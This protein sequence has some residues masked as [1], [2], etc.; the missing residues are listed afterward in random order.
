MPP[1]AHA[2]VTWDPELAELRRRSGLAQRMGGE[3]KVERHHAQSKLTV[4]E[5]MAHDL[6]LSIARLVDGSGGGG[7]VTTLETMRASFVPFNPAWEWV[8]ANLSTVPVVSLCLG[9]VAG[10]GAARVVTSRY[11]VM[12]QGTSQLFVAG[13]PVVK[14]LGE[15]VDKE[16]L[17]GSHS[18]TRNGAVDDEVE[19]EV[20]AFAR[21]SLPLVSPRERGR[22][23]AA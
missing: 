16:T 13:P 23:P 9:S 17:G 8:V 14:R 7:S 3:E 21:P 19:S 10:L 15:D 12:V 2:P 6:G 4:R 1:V 11:S 5:R 22:A 20:E 18:H